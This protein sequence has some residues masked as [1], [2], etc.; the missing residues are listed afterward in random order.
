MD[1]TKRKVDSTKKKQS[2]TERWAKK[3][4]KPTTSKDVPGSGM[5]KDTAKKIEKRRKMIDSI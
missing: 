2:E 5:A 4:K 3:K 1:A